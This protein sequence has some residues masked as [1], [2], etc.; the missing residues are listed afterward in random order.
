MEILSEAE[1]R[2]TELPMPQDERLSRV[3]TDLLVNQG[4]AASMSD[5]VDLATMSERNFSRLFI[6]D[7]G[8]VSETGSSG[9][10]S[11]SRW[12]YLLQ[13]FLSSRWPIS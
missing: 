3:A 1:H 2:V 7:K 11:A 12:I 9:R 10:G 13:A 5:L 6:R 8:S 4:W